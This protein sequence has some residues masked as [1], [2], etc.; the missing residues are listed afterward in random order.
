MSVESEKNARRI[1]AL[2]VLF[3]TIGILA[4][5]I[6]LMQPK[7]QDERERLAKDIFDDPAA[8]AAKY[9]VLTTLSASN[10]AEDIPEEEK[11]RVL[12]ALSE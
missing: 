2:G 9:E 7:V 10:N 11:L 4:L 1:L 5:A 6:T 8:V 12:K 3:A